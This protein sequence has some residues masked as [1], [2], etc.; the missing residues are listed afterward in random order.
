M[1]DLAWTIYTAPLE[2]IDA[3]MLRAFLEQ[4]RQDRLFVESATLELKRER[5]GDNVVKAI[6]GL[7]NTGGGIVLIG[8]DDDPPDFDAA[9]GVHPSEVTAVL[10][11]CMTVLTPGLEPEITTVAVPGHDRVIVVIRVAS[12]PAF[13]PVVKGGQIFLRQP[14]QTVPATHTQV[15]DLVA[16]RS[17]AFVRQG[18]LNVPS[19]FAV[20]P[21]DRPGSGGVADLIVR[22]ATAAHARYG[23]GHAI[24]L[25][26]SEREG[27]T[28][29]VDTSSLAR[30]AALSAPHLGDPRP[31]WTDELRVARRYATRRDFQAHPAPSRVSLDVRVD[32]PQVA[33]ALDFHIRMRPE[34]ATTTPRVRGHEIAAAVCSAVDSLTFRLLPVV[35]SWMSGAPARL[36]DVHCWLHIPGGSLDTGIDLSGTTTFQSDM[37][38]AWGGSSVRSMTFATP[39]DAAQLE[40]AVR[41]QL[42]LLYLDL[43]VD[44]EDTVVDADFSQANEILDRLARLE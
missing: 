41:E 23:S 7:A 26:S 12:N 14:G 10:N 15:L 31:S 17:P 38:R 21:N 22:V 36:E 19:T 42:K 33:I 11:S 1:T 6:A 40:E 35:A 28:S 44:H 16:R 37:T 43:G 9:P 2:A 39:S 29:A 4:Q 32:G 34:Q 5:R 18:L 20:D 3:T 30:L 27:L 8:V 24:A 25:G 13:L